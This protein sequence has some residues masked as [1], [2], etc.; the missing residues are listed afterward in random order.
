MPATPIAKSAVRNCLTG[1]LVFIC[2]QR[3]VDQLFPFTFTGFI[4]GGTDDVRSMRATIFAVT[5][6][7]TRL[8]SNPYAIS[9]EFFAPRQGLEIPKN[10]SPIPN[11]PP[12]RHNFAGANVHYFGLIMVYQG[13]N[14]S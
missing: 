4:T 6:D 14:N 11:Q 10:G 1:G 2:G 5:L 3:P 13:S 9:A 7:S 8:C 12:W